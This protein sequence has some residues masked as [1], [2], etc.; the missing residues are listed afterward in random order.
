MKDCLYVSIQGRV[1]GVGFR[2]YTQIEARK[3]GISG[4][5]RNQP[6]GSVEACICGEAGALAAMQAWL[7]HGPGFAHVEHI[8]FSAGHLP[9]NCNDFRIV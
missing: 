9:D 6:D 1:Q 8:E 7:K 3:L 2:Y 5:V 4:W